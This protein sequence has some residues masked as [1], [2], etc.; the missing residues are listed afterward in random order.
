MLL[1]ILAACFAAMLMPALLGNAPIY[2]SL[3]ARDVASQSGKSESMCNAIVFPELAGSIIRQ[4]DLAM[5]VGLRWNFLRIVVTR[6][7]ARQRARTSS[8]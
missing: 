1:A 5:A 4:L 7:C 2:K 6:R 8:R 3:S